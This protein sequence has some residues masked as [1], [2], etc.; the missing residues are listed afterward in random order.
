MSFDAMHSRHQ[1]LLQTLAFALRYQGR[2]RVDTAGRGL[3]R[4]TA[5][6]L[7]EHL[8]QSGFVVMKRPPRA[9]GA[10]THCAPSVTGSLD[11][12]GGFPAS[13]VSSPAL[14][15]RGLLFL[16]FDLSAEC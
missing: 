5:E 1:D 15:R 3:V 4:I 13:P 16:G 7:A 10:D 12:R 8:S 9:G 11:V 6:R 14:S 2:K